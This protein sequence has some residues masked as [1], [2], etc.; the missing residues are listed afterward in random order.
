MR[1]LEILIPIPLALYLMWPHPRPRPVRLLPAAALLLTLL[2]FVIEGYRWQMVPL[3]VMAGLLTFGALLKM[4]STSDWRSIAALPALVLVAVSTALPILLPVPSIPTPSGPFQVGTRSYELTD[5]SRHEL[6]SGTQEARRFQIRIWYPAEVQPSDERAPWMPRADIF[7]PAIATYIH[8]PPFFLDHLALVK[9]PAYEE[10]MVAP[11]EEGYPVILFSH[12]W[13]GF[14]AQNTGQAIELASHGYIVVGVQHP[15]GA[16][17][18]VF[19]DGTIAHNNPSALPSG[20]PDEEYE[21]AAQKLVDQWAHDLA[22]ALNFIAS[23]NEDAASPFHET[24]DLSRVGVY[25]HSTG[26]GAAIQFCGTDPRCTALLGMDPFMRPVSPQVLE[27]GVPQPSFF[28]FSQH[29]ADDTG[30]RN[31]ELFRSFTAQAPQ[32]LGLISIDGT[33]HYDF[34][35]LPRLSPLAPRLGLKGPI[36]GERVTT[37][38]ND[39]LIAFFDFTLKDMPTSLFEEENQKYNEARFSR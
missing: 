11:A 12:G 15:Y 23:Q 37:I 29:W 24:M 2:H 33:A 28:M 38:I 3:Y 19:E 16:V 14:N 32:M 4:R 13:N 34:S 7:A 21:A 17:I 26:G 1:P 25:G 39:Y 6:Y 9:T 30:S 10:A 5:S 31:N 8:M 18:T 35:D 22:Y 27:N 20:A 36:S